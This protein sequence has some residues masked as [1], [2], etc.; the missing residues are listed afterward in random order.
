[1]SGKFAWIRSVAGLALAGGLWLSPAGGAMAQ[2]NLSEDQAS[3]MI[4]D[5]YGVQVVGIE[6]AAMDGRQVF[7]VRVMNPPGD[8]NEAFQ[9]NT[10]V[11][12]R[13]TGELVPQFRHAPSG[14]RGAGGS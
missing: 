13:G 3:R 5:K 10:L 9:V 11:V 1:M 6:A 2:A 4:E 14:L 8:F 12:D 7:I